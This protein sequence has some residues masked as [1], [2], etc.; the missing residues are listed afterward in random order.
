MKPLYSLVLYHTNNS[1]QLFY[2]HSISIETMH[3][4]VRKSWD[5]VLFED[6]YYTAG[7][8]LDGN[9]TRML[10][11]ILNNSWRQHP[12][13]P[14]LYGHQPP[15]TKT[16][17]IRRT[18]YVGHCW[19]SRDELISDVLLWT[20]SH[21]QAKSGRPARIY[22]QQLWADEGCSLE[23]LP[24]AMDDREVWWEMVRNTRADS[25]T[26]WWWWC[27]LKTSSRLFMQ[28]WK[29]LNRWKKGTIFKEICN[30]FFKLIY[31]LSFSVITWET[32]QY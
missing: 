15:I 29:H 19:R 10:R 12:T 8:K 13:K 24:E 28:E 2:N 1:T 23:D 22:I 6:V 4:P 32:F 26:W 21:E 14:Q 30:L 31:L 17:K 3:R 25:A 5:G 9:Y 27:Y 11:V 18:R 20:P 16:I 7:K